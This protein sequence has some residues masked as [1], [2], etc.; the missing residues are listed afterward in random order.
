MKRHAFLTLVLLVLVVVG[1]G[2][3]A[4]GESTSTTQAAPG[5]TEA[6]GATVGTT[7]PATQ[8]SV[9]TG[10]AEEICGDVFSLDEVETLFGEPAEY[11]EDTANGYDASLGRILCSWST[12]EDSANL[13]DLA[14]ETL[15]VQVYLGDPI[16][17]TNFYSPDDIYE[18]VRHLDGIGE[19]AYV[20]G[21]LGLDLGFLDGQIAAFLSYAT[22]DL[23]D[24]GFVGA[25]E[26]AAIEYLR[27]LHDRVTG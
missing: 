26:D 4:T 27:I 14:F 21:S 18:D 9:P 12:L 23:G 6:T 1:C 24:S 19:N 13:T 25:G 22:F 17:G 7:A 20:A 8:S 3:D 16:A 15:V 2:D 5:S 10:T 11:D